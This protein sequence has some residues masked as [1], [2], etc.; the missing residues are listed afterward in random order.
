MG[1]KAGRKMGVIDYNRAYSLLGSKKEKKIGYETKLVH[2]ENGIA[3]R[4][5]ATDIITYHPD[6]SISLQ[7]HCS[8]TTKAR[9]NAYLTQ[10]VWSEKGWMFIQSNGIEYPFDG[11]ITIKADGSIDCV[12]PRLSIRLGEFLNKDIPTWEAAIQ[13]IKD[14]SLEQVEAVWK[15]FKNDRPFIARSCTERFLPLA[16]ATESKYPHREEMWRDIVFN[17]LQ[18][19][20]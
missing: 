14:L 9:Y 17:R 19:V 7:A 16:L 5:W 10:R 1:Y 11:D 8:V 2:R 13:T 6:G 4:H 3:V 12:P 20:A 18:K 15:K